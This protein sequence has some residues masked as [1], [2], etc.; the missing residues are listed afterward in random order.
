MRFPHDEIAAIPSATYVPEEAFRTEITPEYSSGRTVRTSKARYPKS[1]LVTKWPERIWADYRPMRRFFHRVRG[2]WRI[3]TWEDYLGH[4]TDGVGWDRVYVGVGD[5]SKSQWDLPFSSYE[6]SLEL[7]GSDLLISSGSYS[8]TDTLL[9]TPNDFSDTPGGWESNYDGPDSIDTGIA[10]PPGTGSNASRLNFTGTGPE[11]W[12]LDTG[13]PVPAGGEI[14]T[15]L[16]VAVDSGTLDG[17]IEA[18]NQAD[19]AASVVVPFTATTTWQKVR[20]RQ[21]ARVAGTQTIVLSF[22]AAQPLGSILVY[23]AQVAGRDGRAILNYTPS[24]GVPIDVSGQFRRMID[25]RFADDR[26]ARTVYA[27]DYL[28]DFTLPLIEERIDE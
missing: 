6:G 1:A 23:G 10:G 14:N 5:G 25:V 20:A 21:V 2:M 18:V 22:P 12:Y 17:R 4:D 24:L 16:W 27:N 19:L 9:A 7:Y 11:D 8:V 26:L 28:T 3:W 15:G 13:I